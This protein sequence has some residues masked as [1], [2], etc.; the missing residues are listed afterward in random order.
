MKKDWRSFVVGCVPLLICF[1]LM[2]PNV[3]CQVTLSKLS[4]KGWCFYGLQVFYLGCVFGSLAFFLGKLSRWVYLPLFIF[5]L[6]I[7]V[8]E[9]YVRYM[10]DVD[11]RGDWILILQASSLREL[12]NYWLDN[13]WSLTGS[14]M[15]IGVFA[16]IIVKITLKTSYPKVSVK[17]CL[18]GCVFLL[19]MLLFNWVG[20]YSLNYAFRYAIFYQVIID[21]VTELNTFSDLGSV[22]NHPRGIDNVKLNVPLDKAPT[23]V[24]VIGESATRNSFGIYGYERDTTPFLSSI[25]DELLIFKDL[26]GVWNN[27]PPSIRYLFTGATADDKV[28]ARILITQALKRVGYP[29]TFVSNQWRWGRMNNIITYIFNPADQC[30][31]LEDDKSIEQHYDDEML[32]Y[33][34]KAL[35]ENP[36][37]GQ[38]IYLHQIGSHFP[39]KGFY[40]EARSV[41]TGG[42]M[43]DHYDN[44]I[45]FT[46][47]LI[48]EI[49]TDLKASHRPA[50][51]FYVS[52]HGDT[53]R[54]ASW[55][56]FNDMDLW[57]LPMFVWFSEEYK[58]AFP[59][60]VNDVR[61]ALEKP[62][63]S[64]QVLPGLLLMLQVSGW[65]DSMSEKCFLNPSFVP[66]QRRMIKQW[67]EAYV[68]KEKNTDP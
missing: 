37:N 34:R 22:Y 63:Q 18:I 33:F 32:P 2:T 52:D 45:R 27:T 1:A 58:A 67:K 56:Q 43:I 10:F 50:M 59:K 48:G 28:H 61:A 46:D 57:E 62:L 6:I 24:I 9:S 53:P 19:P 35:T 29:Q 3:F 47:Y 60:T 13:K 31:Y 40:P 5:L 44:T 20:H 54:A 15:A 66:R 7:G 64:D 49:I 42:K 14:L 17:S 11:Y 39:F 4:F 55:R 21:T 38:V 41:F 16:Y 68:R 36:A 12:Y 51:L 26:V 8:S 25:K 65:A 30:V 23:C